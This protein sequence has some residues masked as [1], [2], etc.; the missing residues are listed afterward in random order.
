VLKQIGWQ[1]LVSSYAITAREYSDA[2]AALGEA[3]L[4]PEAFQQVLREVR[5]QRDL[6][7]EV[8]DEV[9]CYLRKTSA[10]EGS[11]F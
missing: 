8:A 9:E 4:R 11:A 7:N 10:A 3:H 1:D 6:C 2:V 5:R